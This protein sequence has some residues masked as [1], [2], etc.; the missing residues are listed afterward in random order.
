MDAEYDFVEADNAVTDAAA[1]RDASAAAVLRLKVI[2]GHS[3]DI[4]KVRH[5]MIVFSLGIISSMEISNSS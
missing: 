3:F 2:D 4:T 1:A 5:A